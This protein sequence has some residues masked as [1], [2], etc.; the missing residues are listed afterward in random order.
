MTVRTMAVLLGHPSSRWIGAAHRCPAQLK[1][2]FLTP[3]PHRCTLRS[4][5]Y[6]NRLWE[7][8]SQGTGPDGRGQSFTRKHT[9]FNNVGIILCVP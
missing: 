4:S 2:E 7:T 9:P 1:I 6:G 3:M 8:E 5:D